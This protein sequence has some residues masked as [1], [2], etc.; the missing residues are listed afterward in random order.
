MA[1]HRYVLSSRPFLLSSLLG[2]VAEQMG[3][4]EHALNAY[5]HALRHNPSSVSGLTQVAGIARIKENY[6]KAVDYFQRVLQI[7]EDNGEIWSALGHC[8]LMQDDLQKAYSAYQ[9]ALYLLPNPKEDPKLWY[10]IGIL[11]DRYGSLDHAEEAFT[12][13]LRMCKDLDF[14]KENE[15]L[16]RLG[17]I[18]KQQGKFA[19]SLD[20]FDHILRNPPS[21]L[22]LADIW[23]QIGHVFEQQ[24]NYVAAKDAYERV[25][26]A[27]PGHAKVL[28]QLG[29]LYHQ[30]GSTFQSQELA[31]SYLTKSLEAGVY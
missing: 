25:V 17:I 5:E 27:N 12:S 8:Y 23:F 21:P 22:A 13:V 15:I 30:D 16:F 10:G 6:A 26:E 19:E 28:Q 14:D 7:D 2:R 11:Y 3:D 4:L 29:W 9:Q 18:Y 20:C 31:I 24:K 1:P